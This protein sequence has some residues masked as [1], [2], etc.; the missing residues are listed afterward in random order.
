MN[1]GGSCRLPKA[2]QARG[3]N[4][5]M[6]SP[7]R[8]FSKLPVIAVLATALAAGLG[9]Y[10][11]QQ[12]VADPPSLSLSNS[13]LY[14]APR[15]VPPFTLQLADGSDF[16]QDDL[17]N[18]WWLV[19]I[20]F[21]HCPDICPTTLQ[22]LSDAE[23]LLADVDPAMRPR[24]LFVSVDP[25][26]DTAAKATEYAHYFSPDALAATSTHD[27]LNPFARSF[28]LVYMQVPLDGGGYT[29]DHS[30]S[31]AIVNPQGQQVGLVRPPLDPG[32][33]ADDL[34]ALIKQGH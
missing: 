18:R 1:I 22:A 24:I 8:G 27:V 28:G 9:L 11:G 16:D 33:I 21:T 23:K 30:A 34:H 3:Y 31:I 7:V 13:L 29:V 6:K 32:K 2:A 5:P 19:F 20:G 4:P 25:E 10:F 15:E 26:R 12:L 14:P 17:K